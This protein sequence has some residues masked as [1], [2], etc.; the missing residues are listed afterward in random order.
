M[1]GCKWLDSCP[2]KVCFSFIQSMFFFHSNYD[3]IGH[4]R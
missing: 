3:P 4:F 2:F 1:A